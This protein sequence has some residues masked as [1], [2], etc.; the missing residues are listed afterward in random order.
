MPDSALPEVQRVLDAVRR[1]VRELRLSARA[2]E[3]EVGVSAAQLFVLQALAA[4]PPATHLTMSEL[5]RRTSTD[6]SSVSVVV[7]RLLDQALITRARSVLDERKVEVA[8]SARG[9]RLLARA[10]DAAQHRLMAAL[11]QLSPNKRS[12]LAR[13]LEEVVR[14]MGAEAGAAPMF[15]EAESA[16]PKR[17]RRRAS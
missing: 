4:A 16:A 17:G 5:S 8:L 13:L 9:R 11:R 10:P 1:I 2:A 12:T 14:S 6:P 3:S 7:K 15:F